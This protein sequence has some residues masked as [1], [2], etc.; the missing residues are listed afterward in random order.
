MKLC[1]VYITFLSLC[2]TIVFS[3]SPGGVGT[4]NLKGWFDA[5]LGVTLSAGFVS[6]WTD[7]SGTGNASQATATER[8]TQTSAA[9]NYNPALTFDGND[10]N[11]GLVDRMA[12]TAT[13]VS[14]YAVAFQ[15]ATTRDTWGSI[16]NGQANGPSWVGGGYGIVALNSGSTQHGF[17]VRD[18][19]TKGV[20]FALTNG[21]PTLFAGT[22]NGTTANKVEAFK[23]GSSAGTVAYT[24]GSVGDQGSTWIGSGDGTNTDWCF[25]GSIAEIAVFNTGLSSANNNLVTS[26]LALKYAITMNMNY[27]NSASSTVYS[28][29]GTYINNIIGISRDDNSLL[30]QKQS[31]NFDDTVRIYLSTLAATNGA[32]GG[33]FAADK[34]HVVVGADAGKM[35]AYSTTSAEKPVGIMKR[36][37]RE[38]K[39]TN[40][41]FSGTFS[42]D[43]KLNSCAVLGS[44][45]T[46]DLRLIVDDDGNFAAGTTNSYASGS[47]GLTI[48][49]SNPVITVSGISTAMIASGATNYITI[50]SV[51]SLSTPLPVT[52]LEFTA[53]RCNDR[54]CISWNV[55]S[56]KNFSHYDLESS[57]DC[58]TFRSV[59]LINSK[60]QDSGESSYQQED[61]E[62]NTP[63]TYYRLRMVDING[64]VE[65]SKTISVSDKSSKEVQ[66]KLFPNP[67]SSDI[68]MQLSNLSSQ[69]IVITIS[70]L[71]GQTVYTKEFVVDPSQKVNT[72]SFNPEHLPPGS[73]LVSFK[74]DNGIVYK[75]KLLRQ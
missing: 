60:K 65:T 53:Q 75:E 20:S 13:G 40:T 12:S 47:G 8:P 61:M 38:W 74:D 19:N 11:L 22:W 33:S 36:L 30:L 73:Y 18:Y 32:N 23:N 71:L 58:I 10:D 34:S 62:P 59:A 57:S 70:S 55:E 24:P 72:I 42:M 51:N 1:G 43:F 29:T 54:N 63:V 48:S 66:F 69:S 4:A 6:A 16:F 2:T 27:L 56:E 52:L 44:V 26:Y 9:I 35:C 31:K 37:D 28:P 67:A 46:S 3:Q 39:V 25:Y 64:N 14:A 21:V 45:N 15:T 68:N 41:N 17:Y 50:G 5:N 7:Q 49:Y